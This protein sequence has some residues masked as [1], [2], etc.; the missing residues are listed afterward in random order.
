VEGRAV[1]RTRKRE[2]KGPGG[3][4]ATVKRP[5][6]RRQQRRREVAVDESQ[7]G[8]KVLTTAK[9]PWGKDQVL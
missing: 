6:G 3:D 5:A 8:L 7:G 9:A 2:K 1:V 4:Q